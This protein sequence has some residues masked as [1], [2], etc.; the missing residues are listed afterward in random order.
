MR[1]KTCVIPPRSKIFWRKKKLH[2]NRN[3][4]DNFFLIGQIFQ[5]VI[6]HNY[7]NSGAFWE[8]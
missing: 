5:L 4:C 1:F 2:N 3:M 7:V 8:L 6:G